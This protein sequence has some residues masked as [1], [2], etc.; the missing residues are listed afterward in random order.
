MIIF[1]VTGP[2]VKSFMNNLLKGEML[3]EFL[4]REAT[5]Q[6]F[7]TFSVDGRTVSDTEPATPF[8]RWKD[9]KPYFYQL[10]KGADK[11]KHFKIIFSLDYDKMNELSDNA[12]ALFLNF[13][14]T[15]D[16]ITLTT[17][18]A[19]KN[20]VLDK[21]LDIIWENYITEFFKP[22]GIVSTKS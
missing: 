4:V 12:A 7:V 19:Q 13:S 8:C 14:F 1:S 11:P 17:G 16:E 9:L 6:T 5:L 10:I 22:F 3:D 20:F 21:S 2:E 15:D 18:T